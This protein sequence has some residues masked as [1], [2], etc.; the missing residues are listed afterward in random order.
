MST[1]NIDAK[2]V[3]ALRNRTGLGF[4]DCRTALAETGADLEKAE[5]LLRERLKGKMDTR[6]DRAAGEG[7]IAIAIGGNNAAIVE[8]RA[9][10]DFTAKNEEFRAMAADLATQALAGSAGAVTMSAAMTSRLD[11]VRIKTGENISFAKGTHLSGGNFA[12][13]LHHDGKL[14]VLL[15]FEGSM[16]EDLATGICQHVAA[17]VPPPLAVDEH[18]L[19]ADVVAAKR[20]EAKKEAAESG[21]P[22]NIIEKMAEGKVRKF[23]EETTLLG[24]KYVRNDKVAVGNLLPEGTK[25]VAFV[26]M[27]VGA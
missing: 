1:A 20:E 10:T 2:L 24:Q 25:I 4:G 12:K 6:S 8:V 13:Y 17:A 15:Q 3:M 19:P 21:K 26:R 5:A 14:G 22:A 11:G 18:G 27:R 7:C 9:E 23:F 16:P